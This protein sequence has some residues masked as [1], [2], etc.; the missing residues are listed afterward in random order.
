MLQL[1]R[2]DRAVF[3]GRRARHILHQRRRRI[4]VEGEQE[5]P[6]R[7]LQTEGRLTLAIVPPRGVELTWA[8]GDAAPVAPTSPRRV[9]KSSSSLGAS[10]MSFALRAPFAAGGTNGVVGGARGFSGP[11]G[12]GA[13]ATC[14]GDEHP[15]ARVETTMA[16]PRRRDVASM[17]GC[18]RHRNSLRLGTATEACSARATFSALSELRASR[19]A[20]SP[21]RR[22]ARPLQARRA[23]I[24]ADARAR[25]GRP[26]SHRPSRR[27]CRRH[28]HTRR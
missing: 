6:L 23:R 21:R 10:A 14:D 28:L 13:A 9:R 11:S 26:R 20:R 17:R 15:A 8:D 12:D 3:P 24:G 25:C 2:A 18:L 16:K 22:S 5:R 19:G 1:V 7:T 4:E 27:P